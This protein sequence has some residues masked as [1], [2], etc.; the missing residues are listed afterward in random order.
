MWAKGQSWLQAFISGTFDPSSALLTS[1]DDFLSQAA[2]N[3]SPGDLLLQLG[4]R[5]HIKH[6]SKVDG[7]LQR[8]LVQLL[9]Q[10][11]LQI[12]PATLILLVVVPEAEVRDLEG[13]EVTETGSH[14]EN[15]P[16]ISTPTPKTGDRVAMVSCAFQRGQ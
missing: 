12:H 11:F 9:L 5:G 1:P 15:I 6:H 13:R 4:N 7:G 3:S 16:R 10:G 2:G 14:A 8:V